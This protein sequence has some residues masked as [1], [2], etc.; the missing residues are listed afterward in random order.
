M[1]SDDES[2]I[3]QLVTC[4]GLSQSFAS[5]LLVCP[6]FGRR[7]EMLRARASAPSDESNTEVQGDSVDDADLAHY[8]RSVFVLALA[9]WFGRMMVT[10]LVGSQS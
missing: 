10:A 1:S 9:G 6:S 5:E 8:F 3:K 4:L 2:R 7:T